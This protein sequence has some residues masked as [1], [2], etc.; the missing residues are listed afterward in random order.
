M[1][2]KKTTLIT[3]DDVEYNLEDMSDEQKIYVRHCASLNGKMESARFNLDQLIG[4][5]EYF[6]GLLKNSLTADAVA[7]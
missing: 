6:Y 3:V 1:S 4:G 7:E 2:E 5:H